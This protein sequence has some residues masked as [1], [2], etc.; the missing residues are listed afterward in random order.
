MKVEIAAGH[1]GRNNDIQAMKM[2]PLDRK[3][4]FKSIQEK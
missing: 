4:N 2:V 1:N 3:L